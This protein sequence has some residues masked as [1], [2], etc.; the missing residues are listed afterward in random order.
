ML[1]DRI[2]M[3]ITLSPSLLGAAACPILIIAALIYR[4]LLPRPIPG[5]PYNKTSAKRILGDA[6]DVSKATLQAGRQS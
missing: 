4:A 5:I 3:S 2:A 6:P 1:L